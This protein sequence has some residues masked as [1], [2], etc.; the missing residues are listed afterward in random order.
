MVTSGAAKIIIINSFYFYYNLIE[1]KKIFFNFHKN[2]I[3][4]D[5]KTLR[6]ETF[7]ALEKRSREDFLYT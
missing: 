4:Q 5:A 3:K 1:L 6:V 2:K 7:R